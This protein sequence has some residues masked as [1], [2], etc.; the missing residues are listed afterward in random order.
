M[1]DFS[2]FESRKGRLT[3][4]SEEVYKFVTDIRNFE[5][6]IPKGTVNSWNAEKE[7]CSFNVA[8][9]GT[10]SVRLDEKE[11]FTRVKFTGDALKK[12][13]FSL[14]LQISDLG[15]NSAGV[16]ISLSAELNPL[17]K[18]MATNPITRFIELLITEMENFRE[19]DDIKK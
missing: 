13:D 19:W 5:R 16:K 14:T 2:Y 8:M 17:M 18:M 6:F 7:T 3:C 1:A 10:T 12:N 15:T 4:N 9:L 11:E